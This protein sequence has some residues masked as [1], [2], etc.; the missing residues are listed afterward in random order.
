MLIDPWFRLTA[1]HAVLEEMLGYGGPCLPT[2]ILSY[3]LY[4]SGADPGIFKK[5]GGAIYIL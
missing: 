4:N 2:T 5:G 3:I 1:L